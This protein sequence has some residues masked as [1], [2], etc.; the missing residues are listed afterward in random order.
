MIQ[1]TKTQFQE[2]IDLG[3]LKE[4]N[5]NWVTTSVKKK[6]KRKKKY[7]DEF[8]FKKY[9]ADNLNSPKVIALI[10]QLIKDKN[11]SSKDKKATLLD[12]DKVLGFNLGQTKTETPKEIIGLAEERQQARINKDWA[13]S[14]V[15]RQKIKELGYEIKD[16]DDGYKIK[17]IG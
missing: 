4:T 7:V 5:K 15:L 11:V 14:D 12:F 8:K 2:M 6:S 3:I 17:K 10:W 16:M 13:K 1:I 9:L